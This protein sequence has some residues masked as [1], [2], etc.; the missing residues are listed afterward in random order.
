MDINLI[1]QSLVS[2]LLMGGVF[3]LIAI[4]LTLIFG[5]MDIIN[6]AHGEFVMLG[7]YFSYFLFGL[8]GID[9]YV[10]ILLG[11][12]LFF[13]FGVLIQKALI[14]RVMGARLQIQILLTLGLMLFLQNSALFLWGSDFRSIKVGYSLSTF[15]L[16]PILFSF[17]RFV[18]FIVAL[19]FVALLYIFLRKSDIGRAIRACAV[20]KDGAYLVGINVK[21]IFQLAFGIGIACAG[22]A[23][24]ILLP[25]F[26]LSPEVGGVF[27]VNAFIIVV[28]GGMG[29]FPGA[30]V[31]G[32]IIGI[33]EAMGEAFLPGSLKQVVSFVIFIL[34]M[35]F[36]PTGL[37][38]GKNA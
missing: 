17:P 4:G 36:K 32:L 28:L 35:Y 15:N 14:E 37:M 26:Y 13:L 25:F 24:S 6:F 8:V 19:A 16:G 5:V 30:L 34:I 2:G 21:R 11:I 27:V 20:E 29:N 33:A 38:G 18:A 7:M 3:A 10:S 23:G 12:P 22:A 1:L 9:P 31:G